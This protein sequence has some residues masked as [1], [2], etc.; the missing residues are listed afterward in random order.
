[1]KYGENWRLVRGLDYYMRTTFEI[2][3][4]GLGSQNA[5]CGG[6]RYD[7]LIELL[8]GPP[9]KGIG[10]AIGEDRLILSLQESTK[11]GVHSPLATRHSPLLFIAWMGGEAYETAIRAAKT[12][13]GAGISVELPPAELKFGKALAQADKLGAKYAL[14]LG[15]NEVQSGEWA[16]KTLADGSQR[17]LT[18]PQL[19]E[20]LRR[21]Q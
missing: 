5:V 21:P 16:L 11:S 19:L 12:L 1:M 9:T 4:S 8:G 14:I 3:A 7:G 6:G 2:T 13:R 15:D 18:E 17:K 20:Y 10:F